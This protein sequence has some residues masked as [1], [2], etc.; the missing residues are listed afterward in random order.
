MCGMVSVGAGLQLV[1]DQDHEHVLCRY[2]CRCVT[3]HR[4]RR[5]KGGQDCRCYL[6]CMALVTDLTP[7]TALA[8]RTADLM[9]AL[10][11]TKPLN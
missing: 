6:S 4:I 8:T 2:G 1:T 11:L 10:E 7:L 5:P 3:V 9:S